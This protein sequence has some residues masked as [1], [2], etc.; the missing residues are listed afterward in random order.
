MDGDCWCAPGALEAMAADLERHP[1]AVAV[2]GAAQTGRS[3][4]LYHRYQRDW[5]WVYGGLYGVRGSHVMR[6]R[7]LGI[8]MPVG[9]KGNDHF[10]T[11]LLHAPLPRTDA[12]E[13]EQVVFDERAGYLFDTLSPLRPADMRIYWNRLVTYNLRQRQ[14]PLLDGVP[15][16]R[17]PENM[18]EVNQEILKD[19]GQH[20]RRWHPVDQAV[21]RKLRRMYPTPD[22]AFY[23]EGLARAPKVDVLHP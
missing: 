7:Q 1:R 6:L 23:R 2:A 4:E 12:F 17:L 22:S 20:R 21:H 3:R 10:V 16:D 19:L 9:L 15:L 18:D 5:G 11:K 8:R 13:R 14:I